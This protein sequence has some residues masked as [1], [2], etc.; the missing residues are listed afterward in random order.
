[1]DDEYFEG[2]GTIIRIYGLIALIWMDS[3]PLSRFS[4]LRDTER[5]I[6]G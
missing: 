3:L 6:F 5:L 1:M 2:L 4:F